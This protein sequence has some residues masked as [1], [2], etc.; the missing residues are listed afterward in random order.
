[1]SERR[2]EGSALLAA[3]CWKLMAASHVWHSTECLLR[4]WD[5]RRVSA[6]RRWHNI[7]KEI[8]SPTLAAAVCSEP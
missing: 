2:L 1:V 4:K 7:D 8:A 5:V 3:D 6:A